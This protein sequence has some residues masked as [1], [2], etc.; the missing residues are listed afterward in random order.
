MS[1]AVGGAAAALIAIGFA[2]WSYYRLPVRVPKGWLLALATLRAAAVWALLFLLSEPLL[3]RH[4]SSEEKPLVVLLA[5]NSESVFWRDA[6]FLQTYSEGIKSLT[7]ELEEKGLR[8]VSYAFDRG[9]QPLDS[10]TGRGQISQLTLAIRQALGSH[11]QAAALVVLSDGQE[12]GESAALPSE[13]PIWTIGVGPAAPIQ[14]LRLESVDLPPWITEK[15]EIAVELRLRHADRPSRLIA[16]HPKGQVLLS[17]PAGSQ[18]YSL[19]LPPLPAGFHT[20]SFEVQD[21]ADPNPTNNQRTV[22]VEI[23]PEKV[24]IFLWAGEITP[25]I[26]FL[27]SRLE[28]LGSVYLIAARKP[29]GYTV[30]PETLQ[31]QPQDL[32]LLY[33]FPARSEDEPWAERLFSTSAYLWLSWG[34]IEP[35]EIFLQKVGLRQWGSLVSH[36]LQGDVTLYLRTVGPPLGAQPIDL[37]WGRPIGYKLYRGNQLRVVLAGEGWW[38]L[39]GSPV[40]EQQWDSVFFAE[41]QEGLRLQRSRWVFAPKRNPVPLGEAVVWSGFL[42]AGASLTVAGRSLPLQS[43][44]E[45]IQEAFWMPDTPGV[46]AYKVSDGQTTLFSGALLVESGSAELQNLGRDTTYLAYIARS[47]GGR[48]IP[49]ENRAAIPESLKAALPASA[50]ITS[51]RLTIPFHEWSLWLALILTLLSAEWLL[52]RYVGLY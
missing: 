25:D 3:I 9:L 20:L 2:L 11:P 7:R 29:A 35:S 8:T 49:W 47:T 16:K 39:R 27:R 33:N 40:L 6:Q 44:P 28:R 42:P 19:R 46:Y 36:S 48:Y 26:A 45:G 10:L 43:R 37:G 12:N 15:E 23:H 24:R 14:D 38:R 4:I 50:F 17:I 32:H 18:R 30:N 1:V 34:A 52:R 41:L 5:D 13:A 21:P 51:Q 22:L 31:W